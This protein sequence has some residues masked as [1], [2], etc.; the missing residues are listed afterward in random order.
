MILKIIAASVLVLVAVGDAWA[1]MD[2]AKLWHKR[3]ATCHGTDGTGSAMMA[4][5]FG[6]APELLDLTKTSTREMSDEAVIEVIRRG[7]GKMPGMSNL[8][9]HKNQLE[10]LNYLRQL[11]SSL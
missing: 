2:A 7:R 3:C 4:K 6:I 8:V 1:K 5:S 9:Y 11:Q 10:L